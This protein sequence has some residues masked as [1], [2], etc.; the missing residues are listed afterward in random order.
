MTTPA[1]SY[2]KQKSSTMTVNQCNVERI[3]RS[4]RRVRAEPSSRQA[5]QDV[6][7]ASL[8]FS[9]FSSLLDDIEDAAEAGTAALRAEEFRQ[10]RAH[11]ARAAACCEAVFSLPDLEPMLGPLDKIARDAVIQSLKRCEPLVLAPLPVDPATI[12]VSGL[13]PDLAKLILAGQHK[14]G[15]WD[16]WVP[17]QCLFEHR[18]AEV[19][20]PFH[21]EIV[22][23][24]HSSDPGW[25]YLCFRNSDKTRSRKRG[26]LPVLSFA[27]LAMP[28]CSASISKGR[29]NGSKPSSTRWETHERLAAIFGDMRGQVWQGQK[30]TLSSGVCMQAVGSGQSLRGIKHYDFRPDCLLLD[31][32]EGDVGASTPLEREAT[33]KWFFG[34]VLPS[35]A[36]RSIIRMAATPL[37]QECLPVTLG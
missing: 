30:V 18:H 27:C 6:A 9:T 19:S 1:G 23:T 34:T 29:S 20:P 13:T 2:L 36:S 15:C 11:M 25:V 26:S 28:W 37:D 31:D 5:R 3:T 7:L 21:A 8:G 32:V 10:R 4:L 35:L 24:F 17:H 16:P 12:Q 14:A 22:E 33:K